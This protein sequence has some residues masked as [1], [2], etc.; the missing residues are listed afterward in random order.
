MHFAEALEGWHDFYVLVGT[1]GATLVA[2]LFVAISLAVGVLDPTPDGTR[3]S[4]L[5][6]SPVVLHFAVVFLLSA[7]SLVP[8]H[9]PVFLA[10]L[11]GAIGAIGVVMSLFNT[12]RLLREW[13]DRS[14][15]LGYG[16]LPAASYAALVV[17]AWLIFQDSDWGLD[18]SGGA[19][20]TLLMVNIRNA[21]DLA[22]TFVRRQSERASGRP[23]P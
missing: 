15:H 4:R 21:W 7:I 12:V 13:N 5:F 23:S 16:L 1:A 14:D 22:I 3:R 20:L 6:I 19:L 8:S 17:A 11:I 9:K 2:L 10:V 18:V